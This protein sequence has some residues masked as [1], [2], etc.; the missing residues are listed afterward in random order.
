MQ[1]ERALALGHQAVNPGSDG[2][3]LVTSASGGTIII[4]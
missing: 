2:F 4:G 1:E 3:L